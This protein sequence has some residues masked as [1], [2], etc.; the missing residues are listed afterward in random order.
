[1]EYGAIDLHKKESQVRI[2]TESGEVIDRRIPT[3]RDRLATLFWGRPHARILVEASTESEWVAQHLETFGHEVVVADP[4]YGLMYG[5]RS[6]R[7]K[8]DRRD[9]AALA[10]ACRHGIYRPTHRRSARQRAVQWHLNV[11]RELVDARTRVISVVRAITRSAGY[12]IA[13]GAT[14]T[15]LTRVTALDLP[16]SIAA[17]LVPGQAVIEV[18]DRELVS[19]DEHFAALVADDPVVKRLTTL[20][21]IGAITATAFVAALDDVHRFDGRRGAG[22]VTCYLG[23]VPREYSSGEQQQRGR[24]MR[25]AHPYVQ[26]LLVQAAWRVCRSCDPRTSALRTWARAIEHR[27]GKKIAIVALARR[28][29]RILYAMWRDE[30]DYQESRIRTHQA[31]RPVLKTATRSAA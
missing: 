8:T 16:A 4:N 10:E 2:I 19:A 20:P 30:V 12:R 23:L 13:G 3:T 7:V 28:V 27:R 21:G 17:S 9:V 24:V 5:H 11:R 29:A 1:M 18:L 22:Q 15:F 6:R 25:S 26:A 14:E 31:G